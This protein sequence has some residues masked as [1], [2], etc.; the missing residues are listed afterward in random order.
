MA[1]GLL[2]GLLLG[3]GLALLRDQFDRR[4]RDTDGIEEVFNLPVLGTIPQSRAIQ[5]SGPGGEL[6]PTG[7][8]GEA[9]RMLRA[10]LRYF[11]VDREIA[12]ILI[13]SAA[14]QDGK[15]TVAWNVAM[16]EARAGK[17]VLYIEADLRRPT[18]SGHLGLSPDTGLSLVLSGA[19]PAAAIQNVQGVD[20]IFAGPLPPNP[21]ELIESQ[22]MTELLTWAKGEYDRVIVDTP[23]AAVVAD[24]VSLF[25]QVDGVVIVARLN[26]SPREAAEHLRDQLANTGAPMLGIVINGVASPAD[27]GYYR[28]QPTAMPF[29]DGPSGDTE[30]EKDKSEPAEKA[31]PVSKSPQ[32]R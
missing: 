4:L 16:S 27:S 14:P 6:P 13:T 22:R 20:L 10:N 8:E 3:V 31:V 21:A 25:S 11:N 29:P 26:K 5:H 19:E 28:S 17:R 24:A 1:L 2:L 23:P 12:S 30:T 7:M 9:F 15:T 32:S 18:L